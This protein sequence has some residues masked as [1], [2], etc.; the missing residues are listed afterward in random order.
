M[1]L[2]KDSERLRAETEV[3]RGEMELKWMEV[4]AKTQLQIAMLL[5]GKNGKQKLTDRN[6]LSTTLA[7]TTAPLPPHVAAHVP[8]PRSLLGK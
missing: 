8:P 5:S 7:L 2:Y 4:I 1:R 6:T 3:R